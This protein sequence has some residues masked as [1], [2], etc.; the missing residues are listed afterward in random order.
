MHLSTT[1]VDSEQIRV[2]ESNQ[3]G[4]I[5][6]S[7]VV[8]DGHELVCPTP[9]GPVEDVLQTVF[10]VP[11]QTGEQM[12]HFGRAETRAA[13]ESFFLLCRAA[14]ACPAAS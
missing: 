1:V 12:A 5:G 14:R 6:V 4:G 11:Q 8:E 9:V 7:V 10:S 2:A 3:A 13:W